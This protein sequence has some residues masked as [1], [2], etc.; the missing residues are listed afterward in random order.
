[1]LSRQL[2][3]VRQK[4]RFKTVK[5]KKRLD[6]HLRCYGEAQ[7]ITQHLIDSMLL[8]FTYISHFLVTGISAVPEA[9]HHT[10]SLNVIVAMT[11][12][13]IQMAILCGALGCESNPVPFPKRIKF[14]IIPQQSPTL[15]LLDTTMVGARPG[16]CPQKAVPPCSC[17]SV[18]KR[19]EHFFWVCQPF[20]PF[21]HLFIC[22][23][24]LDTQVTAGDV[25]A[26]LRRRHLIPNSSKFQ[27]FLHFPNCRYHRGPLELHERLVDVGLRDH[28]TLLL[29]GKCLLGGASVSSGTS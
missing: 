20:S 12:V 27:H 14:I 18:P 16:R 13:S 7:D 21:W 4:R 2:Q 23:L 11:S 17:S 22:T 19:A 15:L 29:K 5:W 24:G 1:M 3:L 26:D 6:R 10:A 25:M 28:S 9:V 8:S